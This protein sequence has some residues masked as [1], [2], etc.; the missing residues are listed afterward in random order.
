MLT[1]VYRY[2]NVTF[3]CDLSKLPS[4][5][6]VIITLN[7]NLTASGGPRIFGVRGK[8]LNGDPTSLRSYQCLQDEVQNYAKL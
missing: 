8:V 3:R 2:L 7:A 6:I 1:M 5:L 4:A